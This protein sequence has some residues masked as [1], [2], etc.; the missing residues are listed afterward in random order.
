MN[1]HLILP[2][3]FLLILVSVLIVSTQNPLFSEEEKYNQFFIGAEQGEINY[4]N[5]GNY[6]SDNYTILF[7]QRLKKTNWLGWRYMRI[8]VDLNEEHINSLPFVQGNTH[9]TKERLK[10][11]R[12]YADYYIK[13]FQFGFLKIIPILSLGIG[14]TTRIFQN[15]RNI[16][17]L[18]HYLGNDVITYRF[19]AKENPELAVIYAESVNSNFT[20]FYYYSNNYSM[21]KVHKKQH[22]SSIGFSAILRF[23]FWDVFFI[24]Q[25]LDIARQ[26]KVKREWVG[27]VYLNFPEHSI[28]YGWI[29]IGFVYQF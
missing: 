13:D 6:A 12:L 19:L 7:G 29:N 8:D 17:G 18:Y 23:L 9:G 26:E 15:Q 16:Y 24:E 1:T 21:W 25:Q 3:R 10:V 4:S 14:Q 27:D 28:G 2:N 20:P 5:H 11:D 22:S